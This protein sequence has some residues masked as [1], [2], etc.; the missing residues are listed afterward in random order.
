MKRLNRSNKAVS[1]S[2]KSESPWEGFDICNPYLSLAVKFRQNM[3]KDVEFSLCTGIMTVRLYLFLL[4]FS[5][6]VSLG[7]TQ[8]ANA[9]R[10]N[11][12]NLIAK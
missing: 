7:K 4:E 10:Q 11:P 5:E 12:I 6:D 9:R 1:D 2:T 3:P 8:A